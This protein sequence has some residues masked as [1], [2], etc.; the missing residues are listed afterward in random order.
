[1]GFL[2]KLERKFGKYAIP[3]LTKYIILTYV[4]GYAML[5]MMKMNSNVNLIGMLSLNPYAILH[6]QVWRL[7]TW[8]IMPPSYSLDIFTLV[9]LF[10]YYSLGT[11]LERTW[12]DFLYNVYIFMGLITTIIGAFILYLIYGGSLFV[13]ADNA[14][15]AMISTY[16][17]SMSIF[18]GFAMTFPEQQMLF[19]FIIPLKIKYLA[20][21]D[22]AVLIYEVISSSIPLLTGIIIF[23]SLAATI[24]FYFL[25]K[26]YTPSGNRQRKRRAEFRKAAG[27]DRNASFGRSGRNNSGSAPAGGYSG[28]I[29]KHKCAVCGQTDQSNPD[30]E[31]RFCSRCNGNYEYCQEHLFTHQ[32][33]Q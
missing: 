11:V 30:L 3:D 26:D 22:I 27:M 19:M 5:I 8:I 16:Y 31:F 14:G 9:M 21:A 18:L 24:I 33:V 17:V 29:V 4:I 10:C 28:H 13:A 6:G 1:M 25:F 7:V 12:G 2:N 32:H 23:S 20:Y 15:V